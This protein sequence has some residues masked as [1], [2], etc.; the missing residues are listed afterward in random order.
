MGDAYTFVGLERCSKLALAFHMGRRTSE[1]ASMFTAK[2]AAAA[3][4]EFQLSTDGFNATRAIEEHLGGRV[5]YGQIIK[6]Y[7]RKR[8]IPSAGIRLPR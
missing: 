6:I 5:D 3:C 4:G 7:G 2:L 1:D 8:R